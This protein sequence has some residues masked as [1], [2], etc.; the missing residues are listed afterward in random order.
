MP[1]SI[2]V[3][4]IA[5]RIMEIRGK[6]VMLDRDLAKLYGVKVKRLKEQVKRNIKRFPGDFMFQLS[7]EEVESLRSHFATLNDASPV[8]SMRGKHVKY[9]PYVF[10]EQGVAML[11]SILNSERAIQVNIMVMRAFVKLK[12]LL[13]THKDL[14]IKIEALERQYAGHDEKIKL[15]FEAIKQLIEPPPA[16]QKPPIG[17]R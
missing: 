1:K 12:E 4:V 8:D 10:T 13:L 17:F 2:A 3:E 15:I 5:T 9:L 11:S 7:W 14:A 6:K 16:P